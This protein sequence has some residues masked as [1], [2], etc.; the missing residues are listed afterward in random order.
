MLLCLVP[1]IKQMYW[2]QLSTKLTNRTGL[3]DYAGVA[4]PMTYNG[5]IKKKG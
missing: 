1:L 3:V 2:I 5:V 4:K